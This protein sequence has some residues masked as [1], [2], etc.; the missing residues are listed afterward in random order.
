MIPRLEPLEPRNLLSAILPAY[1]HDQFTF[2]DAS[3]LAPYG[4]ENT[5]A[6]QSRPE[7][8]K[9]IFLDFDGFHSVGNAWQHDIQFPAFDRDSNPNSFSDSERIEIQKQF[10]NVAEDFL[11]FDVNVT[12]LDPGAAA[13][14]KSSIG[15][16]TWGI[17]AVNTQPTDGFGSGIG[18]IAYL[19]SFASNKDTP[20][21]TFNKGARN[22]GM[23][24]SHEI[25]HALGLR[26]QGLDSQSYHPGAG[27]GQT[28]WGPILGAPFGKRLTQWSNSDY[29]GASIDQDDLATITKRRNGFGYR[30]DDHGSHL[31][32]ATTLVAAERQLSSWGIIERSE[33]Q[34]WFSFQTGTGTVD[35]TIATFGQD[36]NLDIQAILH[37]SNGNVIATSNPLDSTNASFNLELS[38]GQYFLS[39]DG[40]GQTD[41]YSDYGSIGFFSVQGTVAEPSTPSIVGE[42]GVVT[43][44]NHQWQTVQ[45]DHQYENPAIA[46]GPLSFNGSHES[47][48]RIRNLTSSSFDVRIQEWEYLDGWHTTESASYVVVESGI[49]TLEDGTVI[50]AGVATTAS[51]WQSL[52]FDHQFK[53]TPVVFSQAL[54]DSESDAVVTRQRDVSTHGFS[55][56]LQEEE[57]RGLHG[58]ERVGWIAVSTGNNANDPRLQTLV[59]GDTVTHRRTQL[60]FANETENPVFVAAMQTADGGD[61]ANLRVTNLNAQTAHV[62]VDEERSKDRETRHTEE[63]VGAIV[64]TQGDL[65]ATSSRTG[66]G[67]D[68]PNSDK[69]VRGEAGQVSDLNHQWRTIELKHTYQNPAV[70]FGPLSFNGSHEATIR[71]K[72][73]TSTSFDVRIQEWDYLDG[74]HTQES[75]GFMVM[76]SG[77]HTLPDGTIIAAGVHTSASSEWQ[78]LQFGHQFADSPV[79]I[80]Q[81]TTIADADAVVTRQVDITASGF[82]LMLQEEEAGGQHAQEQ[83]AWI[84]VES[85]AGSD[86]RDLHALK[87]QDFV[88]HRKTNVALPDG[89]QS[90]PVIIAAMQSFDGGDTANLRFA[91]LNPDGVQIWVDE[92]RSKDNET[93]HTTESVGMVAITR[94]MI[95]AQDNSNGGGGG[96]GSGNSE[97][98]DIPVPQVS[99]I[100]TDGTLGEATYLAPGHADD[101][102]C[103]DHHGEDHHDEDHHDEDHHGEKG[104]KQDG[105]AT[106]ARQVTLQSSFMRQSMGTRSLPVVQITP[107]LIQKPD[108]IHSVDHGHGFQ[109]PSRATHLRTVAV[110]EHGLSDPS[111]DPQD[112]RSQGQ[113]KGSLFGKTVFPRSASDNTA[114][115]DLFFAQSTNIRFL[116]LT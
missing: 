36:P 105:N 13:L 103:E 82:S 64:L 68:P 109:H 54:T 40:T 86:S 10:Q 78:S 21:F 65:M 71:I 73:V 92:E 2:G 52:S 76:E 72:N 97:S 12:T 77:V 115:L 4:L 67:D 8:T 81:V 114:A 93:R 70:V 56:R 33:D 88:T 53:A 60:Q 94:G 41:R 75:V 59:T 30:S 5:F 19:N 98:S 16:S 102:H 61:T 80:S 22:G 62:W 66:N 101:H 38:A 6:L 87:T 45:L 57:K 85:T 42:A 18:G 79:V 7:A 9:T 26:H 69:N 107:E 91:N 46:F 34:D 89:F 112:S 28:S 83:V 111:S 44:L 58:E 113:S 25:G 20:V 96:S 32:A 49:H 47:T 51:Q 50:A 37:D 23:T 3:S 43:E 14:R 100:A 17:R 31:E 110:S 90:D 99:Y 11:P 39:V 106:A 95:V 1:V 29:D 48:I 74:W 55:L 116:D 15:D 84:A 104:A 108:A 63:V 27:T 35:L 24:N